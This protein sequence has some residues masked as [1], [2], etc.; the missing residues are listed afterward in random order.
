[1]KLLTIIYSLDLILQ[2]LCCKIVCIHLCYH[3]VSTAAFCL[4]L[5]K[6]IF[7]PFLSFALLVKLQDYEKSR[8]S[9]PFSCIALPLSVWLNAAL[10]LIMPHLGTFGASIAS[11]SILRWS[12]AW[13]N[14]GHQWCLTAPSSCYKILSKALQL[15]LRVSRCTV[16]EGWWMHRKSCTVVV[17]WCYLICLV[18]SGISNSTMLNPPRFSQIQLT[19][20]KAY[21]LVP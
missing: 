4:F 16:S 12:G 14:P 19:C 10:F 20:L 21:L 11:L 13:E 18:V 1:M 2:I 3:S 17:S 9:F 5:F 8:I 6:S 15:R 7:M